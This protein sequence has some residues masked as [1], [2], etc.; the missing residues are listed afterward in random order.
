[1]SLTLDNYQYQ[2]AHQELRSCTG[3]HI[4]LIFCQKIYF[5]PGGQKNLKKFPNFFHSEVENCP[6]LNL[7]WEKL[8]KFALFWVNISKIEKNCI[9]WGKK[10]QNLH[11]WGLK[12]PPSHIFHVNSNVVYTER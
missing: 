9:C 8:S 6:K 10:Y 2:L 7:F 5:F 4:W 3:T 1:M 12:L 11:F